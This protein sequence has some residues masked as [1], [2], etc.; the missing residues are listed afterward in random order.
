MTAPDGYPALRSPIVLAGI[1]LRNRV[2]HASMT[3]VLASDGRVSP[4][5]IR[6]HANRA[7]GGAAMT[8]TEPLAMAPHQAGLPRPQVWNDD[9]TDGLK[10]WAEA[11][12][13]LDCRLL[14]QV[15]DGGRGYHQGGRNHRRKISA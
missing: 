6:Y 4:A 9:D 15:Q 14:G 3:T 8:V 12:E 11:V 7:L 10:R 13:S 1:T 5:L 2:V